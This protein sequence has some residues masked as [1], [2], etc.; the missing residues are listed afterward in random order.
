MTLSPIVET[1]FVVALMSLGALFLM[2]LFFL[3][4][5]L[6]TQDSLERKGPSRFVS[7]R[8]LRLGVPFAVYTLLVW[9]LLE[10]AL[11]EPYLH[12]G[13]WRSVG[14]T[15]PVLDNGPVWF[16]GVLLLFSLALVAWRKMFPRPAPPRGDAALAQRAPAVDGCRR[17][18]RS[19]CGSSSQLGRTSR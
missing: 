6:L 10:Y 12:R 7:D 2:A 8:L 13:F 3:I 1:I 18:S 19:S 14:N 17:L 15:D 9:P 11:L 4:S 5:G 16:V